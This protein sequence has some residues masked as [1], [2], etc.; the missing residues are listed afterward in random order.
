MLYSLTRKYS[1]VRDGGV[2]EGPFWILVGASMPSVLVELGYISHPTEVK[3]LFSSSYQKML[4][5]GIADGV[6]A[7]FAK[8]Q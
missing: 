7:Y 6:N 5:R 1:K 8:Q 2:K 3:R 4:A